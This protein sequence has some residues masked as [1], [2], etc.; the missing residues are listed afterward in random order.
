MSDID[1]YVYI[2]R[3]LSLDFRKRIAFDHSHKFEVD[4]NF[5]ELCDE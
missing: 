4:S 5:W 2:N 3:E 1:L